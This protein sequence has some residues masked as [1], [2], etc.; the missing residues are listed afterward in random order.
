MFEVCF[1]CFCNH[2]P[3]PRLVAFDRLLLHL[4]TLLA[5]I[6]VP[7]FVIGAGLGRFT[8]ELMNVMFPHG[9]LGEYMCFEP[10]SHHRV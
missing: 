6:F 2:A 4:L 7:V 10:P 1:D 8:G 3:Y 5:G 9:L